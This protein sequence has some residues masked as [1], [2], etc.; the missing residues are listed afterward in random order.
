MLC[1]SASNHSSEK[2]YHCKKYYD[3]ELSMIRIRSISSPSSGH[4]LRCPENSFVP[5]II[6]IN[7]DHCNNEKLWSC[8]RWFMKGTY[9]VRIFQRCGYWLSL[10]QLFSYRRSHKH[11]CKS[12]CWFRKDNSLPKWCILIDS[13]SRLRL[14]TGRE[15]N[16]QNRYMHIYHRFLRFYKRINEP[17]CK[18]L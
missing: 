9:P 11:F 10:G 2:C 17:M 8:I 3:C 1:F 4:I 6:A 16:I 18:A 7:I 14:S 13:R 12:S 15:H 5:R